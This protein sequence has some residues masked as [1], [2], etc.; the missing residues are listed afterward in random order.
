M[1]GLFEK[2]WFYCKILHL[3]SMNTNGIDLLFSAG[4]GEC[5]KNRD[6]PKEKG[7]YFLE[8]SWS[9]PGES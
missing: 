4:C 7:A 5:G 9:C 2:D 6:C 1:F 8:M 3:V